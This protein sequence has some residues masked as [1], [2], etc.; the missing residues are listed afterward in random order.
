MHIR[1]ETKR[2]ISLCTSAVEEGKSLKESKINPNSNE[3][4]ND[5]VR[6]GRRSAKSASIQINSVGKTRYNDQSEDR[7]EAE[8]R[9]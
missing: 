8:I 5:D 7:E 6:E 4:G 9:K 1:K 3:D 2:K